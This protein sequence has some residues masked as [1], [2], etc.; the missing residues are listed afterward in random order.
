MRRKNNNITI[1]SEEQN[2]FLETTHGPV[3]VWPV[4][5]FPNWDD[6]CVFRRHVY[7]PCSIFI[8]RRNV[9][10][11]IT[12]NWII[13]LVRTVRR[14]RE[15]HA[16]SCCH[17]ATVALCASSLGVYIYILF[18]YIMYILGRV[19]GVVRSRKHL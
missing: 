16:R 12:Y 13:N 19:V 4:E 6:V 15:M 14:R 1:I 11:K 17:R 7:T 2:K 3:R 5:L 18:E 9:Y 10:G 8:S